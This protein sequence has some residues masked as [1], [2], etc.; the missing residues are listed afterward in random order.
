MLR[1]NSAPVSEQKFPGSCISALWESRYVKGSKTRRAYARVFREQ[2][3]TRR[4]PFSF[5]GPC[6]RLASVKS[7]RHA[8]SCICVHRFVYPKASLR[9]SLLVII[10]SETRSTKQF[11]LKTRANLVTISE[12]KKKRYICIE[13]FFFLHLEICVRF[14]THK[15]IGKFWFWNLKPYIPVEEVNRWIK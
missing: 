5:L 11:L 9:R 4:L 10:Q 1:G 2:I 14:P 12:L 13:M 15:G 3:F 8:S 7:H 6:T